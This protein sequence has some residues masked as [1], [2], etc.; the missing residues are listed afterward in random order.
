MKFKMEGGIKFDEPQRVTLSLN[1][2][3][4]AYIEVNNLVFEVDIRNPESLYEMTMVAGSFILEQTGNSPNNATTLGI[5]Q[6][7]GYPTPYIDFTI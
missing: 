1:R 2:N 7:L 5:L 6:H 4:F 3:S